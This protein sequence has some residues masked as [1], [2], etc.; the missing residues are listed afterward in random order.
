LKRVAP[1]R[2][3]GVNQGVRPCV[4]AG[5]PP[6][7]MDREPLRSDSSEVLGVLHRDR[8]TESL[9]GLA[10]SPCTLSHCIASTAR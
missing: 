6:R 10:E 8:S 3:V 2:K 5:W 9:S 7:M 1:P 4:K